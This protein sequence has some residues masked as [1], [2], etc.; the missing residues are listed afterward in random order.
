LASQPLGKWFSLVELVREA[1]A[2]AFRAKDMLLH[3]FGFL[4]FKFW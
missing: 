1:F 3:N 2:G 4:K